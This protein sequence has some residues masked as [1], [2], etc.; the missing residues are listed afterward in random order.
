MV[1]FSEFQQFAIDMCNQTFSIFARIARIPQE[2]C[3]RFEQLFIDKVGFEDDKLKATIIEASA[4]SVLEAA[5]LQR[6][7][8]AVLFAC[9]PQHRRPRCGPPLSL[10]PRA[11]C[12]SRCDRKSGMTKPLGTRPTEVRHAFSSRAVSV[13]PRSSL[14]ASS[15]SPRSLDSC[16]LSRR[17]RTSRR[18]KT[19]ALWKLPPRWTSF[20]PT[21]RGL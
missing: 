15:M 14:H 6:T 2:D 4:L 3:K 16:L 13:E 8:A 11:Q 1:A 19:A 10:S 9:Q 20:R 17:R 12:P 18:K 7:I 5:N 21:Q